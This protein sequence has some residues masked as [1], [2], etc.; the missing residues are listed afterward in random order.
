MASVLDR[1]INTVVQWIHFHGFAIVARNFK[2]IYIFEFLW[3]LQSV[4][5]IILGIN[6]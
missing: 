1:W 3:E 2:A 5:T 6:H 4:K